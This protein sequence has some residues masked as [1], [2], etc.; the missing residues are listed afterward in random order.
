MTKVSQHLCSHSQIMARITSKDSLLMFDAWAEI[1]KLLGGER[2]RLHDPSLLLP[3]LSL[4]SYLLISSSSSSSSSSPLVSIPLPPSLL[5]L[6]DF[7]HGN[8]RIH[9]SLRQSCRSLQSECPRGT[10]VHTKLLLSFLLDNT[11]KAHSIHGHRLYFFK[12][13]FLTASHGM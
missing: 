11:V 4:F 3:F 6:H 2:A 12:K 9:R 13:N 10:Y 5:H 8:S 1:L 7:P